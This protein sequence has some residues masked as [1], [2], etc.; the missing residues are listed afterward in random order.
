[1]CTGDTN[2]YTKVKLC[3]TVTKFEPWDILIMG[4][5]IQVIINIAIEVKQP[6]RYL[7]KDD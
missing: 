3:F 1:M 5:P 4:T 7:N 6:D 2:F